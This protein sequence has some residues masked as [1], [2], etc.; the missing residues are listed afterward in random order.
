MAVNTID[1]YQF[2]LIVV[3]GKK[4]TSDVII[5]PD[6]IR[7]EWWRRKGH[8]LCLEDIADIINENPEVLVVGTGAAGV[9]KVP[10][11]IKEELDTKGIE[12]IVEN[13]EKA[14]LTYNQLCQ[15]RRV[16]AALHLTC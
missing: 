14:C 15:S 12:L 1:D 16:V 7:S 6:S 8:Q 9:M 5:S 11:E 2:G 3:G 10:P 4:Y 13:T